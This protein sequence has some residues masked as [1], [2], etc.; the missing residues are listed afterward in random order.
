MAAAWPESMA[1]ALMA[2]P[3]FKIAG[4]AGGNQNC[5]C[6]EHDDFATRAG[7][8]SEHIVEQSLVGG[9]VAA[10]ELIDCGARK[11]GHLRRDARG[12]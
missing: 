1:S 8:A 11:A 7:N 5:C 4:K 10:G 12:F 9:D 6:V 2:T 3:C